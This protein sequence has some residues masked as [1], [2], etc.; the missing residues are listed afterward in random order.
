MHQSKR[1][2]R[3]LLSLRQVFHARN[4]LQEFQL[5]RPLRGFTAVQNCKREINTKDNRL[6]SHLWLFRK[7]VYPQRLRLYPQN[8]R[9]SHQEMG[10]LKPWSRNGHRR[11]RNWERRL[12]ENK[13][14]PE[15]QNFLWA[16]KGRK[17]NRQKQ[18]ADTFDDRNN[19]DHRDRPCPTGHAT[20]V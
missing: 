18:E 6:S 9:H 15:L 3:F 16:L 4:F 5:K 2:L 19:E 20:E 11:Q 13:E 14:S 12:T 7:Q 17:I 1:N 10:R 8:V